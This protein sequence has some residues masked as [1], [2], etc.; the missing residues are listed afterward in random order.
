MSDSPLCP[1]WIYSATSNIHRAKDKSWFGADYQPIKSSLGPHN[2]SS[3]LHDAVLG[4]GTVEILVKRRPDARGAQGHGVLRLR[5]VL[6]VP[7]CICNVIGTP[8]TKEYVLRAASGGICEI[9]DKKGKA[10]GYF[11]KLD[12]PGQL[13]QLRLSGPPVGPRVGPSPF[14]PQHKYK[15]CAWWH[16]DHRQ[17]TMRQLAKR[18]KKL[19]RPG[20]A[21]FDNDERAWMKREHGS[22]WKFMRAFGLKGNSEEDA[23]KARQIIRSNTAPDM[24]DT[25]GTDASVVESNAL[26]AQAN[27]YFGAKELGWIII[28]YGDVLSFMVSLRL[29][30]SDARDG[31]KAKKI[32]AILMAPDA[33]KG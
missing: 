33:D 19:P 13:L 31:F 20:V 17:L 4:I 28:N 24:A 22:V 16:E 15:I 12:L 1:A 21:A 18:A 6:H 3:S 26:V 9:S 29:K 27:K 30:F 11:Y 14:Q 5:N 8:V 2:V 7:S 25:L 32:A 10:A 23:E